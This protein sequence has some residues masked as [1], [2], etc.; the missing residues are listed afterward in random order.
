MGD[1]T[2]EQSAH[3]GDYAVG[4]GVAMREIVDVR[5]ESGA[6]DQQREALRIDDPPIPC[7]VDI[8]GI[9]TGRHAGWEGEAGAKQPVAD[10]AHM[11]DLVVVEAE[12]LPDAQQGAGEIVD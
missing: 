8:D 11:P 3:D 10:E 6:V 4:R 7:E 9:D 5:A 1:P 2:E 12:L